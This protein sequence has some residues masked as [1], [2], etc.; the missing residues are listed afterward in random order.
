MLSED[1]QMPW[2]GKIHLKLANLEVTHFFNKA[3]TFTLIFSE[4]H[5]RPLWGSIRR[6]QKLKAWNS[7]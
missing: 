7:A 2:K 3:Y 4:V 6:Q 1:T 5:E